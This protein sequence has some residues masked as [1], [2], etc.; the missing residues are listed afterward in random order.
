[1]LK[2][3]LTLIFVFCNSVVFADPFDKYHGLIPSVTRAV[4]AY[5]FSERA[6]FFKEF[7]NEVADRSIADGVFENLYQGQYKAKFGKVLSFQPKLD[8]INFK[9]K[10][11]VVV[12]EAQTE[13]DEK[14]SITAVFAREPLEDDKLKLFELRIGDR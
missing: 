10:R 3:L 14:A 5:N 6:D 12:F 1:M 8:P 9:A 2:L 13:L 7:I 11:P 4:A